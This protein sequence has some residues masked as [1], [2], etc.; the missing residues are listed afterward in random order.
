MLQVVHG[1]NNM[2]K[3]TYIITAFL[4]VFGAQTSSAVVLTFDDIPGITDPYPLGQNAFGA[5]PTYKGFDFTSTLN[6]IDV[7]DSQWNYGATS[8]EFALLNNGGGT[9]I[10]NDA[11][12]IDFTFDGLWA[13]KWN[14]P[15]ESSLTGGTLSG[16]KGDI[17][18]WAVLDT[19]LNSNYKY[20][21]RQAGLIDE[22]RLGFGANFL[23]DDI[24][25]NAAVP[26]PAAAWLFGSGLIGLIG[27]ARRKK[28]A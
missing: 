13:K 23:V 22:L 20:F 17:E 7:V 1:D 15:P 12:S 25:L 18:I 10:I 26:V 21:G 28:T 11:G 14:T 16:Y 27:L 3:F 6:W 9:S 2:K 8:G 19:T 24:K 5:M 4:I